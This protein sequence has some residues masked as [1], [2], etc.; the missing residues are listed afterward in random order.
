[1]LFMRSRQKNYKNK[2]CFKSYHGWQSG[3]VVFFFI[4]LTSILFYAPRQNREK[5]FRLFLN[6]GEKLED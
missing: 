6:H 2:M 4:M 3:V 1:M 5:K